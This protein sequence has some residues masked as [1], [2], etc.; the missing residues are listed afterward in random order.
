MSRSWIPSGCI[1]PSPSSS[2]LSVA[3]RRPGTRVTG[4]PAPSLKRP[5]TL[6]GLWPPG[7][8]LPCRP[9]RKGHRDPKATRVRRRTEPAGRPQGRLGGPED[10]SRS[11][12]ASGLFVSSSSIINGAAAADRAVSWTSIQR[13]LRTPRC[14]ACLRGGA[15]GQPALHAERLGAGAIRAGA[16]QSG[17]GGARPVSPRGT[18][19]QRLRRLLA[20]FQVST[21]PPREPACVSAFKI[22]PRISGSFRR[23]GTRKRGPVSCTCGKA[24]R[25]PGGTWPSS[26]GARARA[27]A[28]A[29]TDLGS[30]DSGPH[31]VQRAASVTGAK[32]P[33]EG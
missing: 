21:A 15:G 26:V 14:S 16:L 3:D 31:S 18:R 22:S 1:R 12:R 5:T 33:A 10:K 8:C 23:S 13:V 7:S 19:D 20:G 28:G 9:M 2:R 25:V 32:G 24:P 11:L 6:W 17:P 29:R 30:R 4:E 27:A